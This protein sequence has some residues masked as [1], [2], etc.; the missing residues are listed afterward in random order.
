MGYYVCFT[1][2][3]R[4]IRIREGK[5]GVGWG[6]ISYHLLAILKS[7]ISS[8]YWENF[9]NCILIYKTILCVVSVDSLSKVGH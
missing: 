5:G 2:F 1:I 4:A 3:G 8:N 6:V 7:R 9:Q